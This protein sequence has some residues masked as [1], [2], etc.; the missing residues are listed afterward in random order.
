MLFIIASPLFFGIFH[1]SDIL[2]FLSGSTRASLEY[3]VRID[4]ERT[5]PLGFD[6]FL[7]H[8]QIRAAFIRLLYTY[9]KVRVDCLDSFLECVMDLT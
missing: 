9:A 3:Q 7:S 6:H 1:V 8:P 5:H 4:V 2:S